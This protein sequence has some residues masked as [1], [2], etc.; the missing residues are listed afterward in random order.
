[1]EN[2]FRIHIF[3]IPPATKQLE[4]TNKN[5]QKAKTK[6]KNKKQKQK[7][8]TKSKNKTTTTTTEKFVTTENN[9][10]TKQ[11]GR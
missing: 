5:K 1:V 7:A 8:K 10:K 9:K 6:S 4:K 3:D 11:W 2:H